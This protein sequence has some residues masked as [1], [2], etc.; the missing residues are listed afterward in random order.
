[1]PNRNQTGP[2]GLGPMTGRGMGVK[3]GI[4]FGQ[5][6]N[7]GF[8]RRNGMAKGRGFGNGFGRKFAYGSTFKQDE[9]F[10]EINS[11]QKEF[12]EN[13]IQILKEK[14]EALEKSIQNTKP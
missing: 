6:F 13:E 12:Y 9:V 8:R 14:V 2:D 7:S 11:T 10:E 1:M 3:S 4:R 5:G